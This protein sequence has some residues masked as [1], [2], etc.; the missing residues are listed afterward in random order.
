MSKLNLNHFTIEITNP[1]NS[2]TK[3][4]ENFNNL[5]TKLKTNLS[6]KYLMKFSEK[7]KKTALRQVFVFAALIIGVTVSAQEFYQLKVYNIEN[8]GQ[9]T[10]MD[11]YL[12]NAYLPALHRAGIKDVGVFK[13][14]ETD[15]TAG[16]KIF[17]FIP[18]R[19]MNQLNKID[20]KLLKDKTYLS[21]GKEFIDASWDN[22][23]YQRMESMVLKA[24]SEMPEYAVPDHSTPASERIYELRSYEGPTEKKYRKKVEMFNE[25]GEVALFQKLEFQPVFFAEVISGNAMPNLMYMT[26]FSDMKAHDEHW[27]AFRKHPEW[28]KLSGMEEYK[29]TVSHSDI[30]LL[31][32]TNYSDI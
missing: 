7:F 2:V 12:E 13:P 29:N 28:K 5:P 17:V 3:G 8:S 24:F 22:P 18:L 26:T 30:W 10:R 16:Q 9:E 25:G 6:N 14:I 23:P 20:V 32:P 31:H 19:N 15:E 1:N 27:D 21:D 4:M 11:N